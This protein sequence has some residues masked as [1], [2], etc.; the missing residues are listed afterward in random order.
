MKDFRDQ[1]LA[2][3]AS[4]PSVE[5][6]AD[7]ADARRNRADF[8]DAK[9][10]GKKRGSGQPAADL[11][12][13]RLASFGFIKS[14]TVE[15]GFGFVKEGLKDLFF[16][17]SGHLYHKRLKLTES[18]IGRSIVYLYGKSPRNGKD[19][20]LQWCFVD[21]L[22]WPAGQAPH[23]QETL[24]SIRSSWLRAQGLRKLLEIVGARWYLS[25]WDRCAHEDKT[26]A[27]LEDALLFDELCALLNAASE[28]DLGTLD[29]RPRLEASP[30][31]FA[32]EWKALG[33]IPP[34]HALNGFSLNVLRHLGGPRA[35]WLRQLSEPLLLRKLAAWGVWTASEAQER[36]RWKADYGDSTK[37]HGQLAFELI[38]AGWTPDAVECAWLKQ[39]I[40]SGGMAARPILDRI[41]ERPEQMG[42]WLEALPGRFIGELI[43]SGQWPSAVVADLAE[44]AENPDLAYSALFDRVVALDLET[45]GDKIWSLGL[46]VKGQR[47]LFDLKDSAGPTLE[48]ALEVLDDA[49]GECVL[50]V[51]HNVQ[52]WDWP[53]LRDR[54]PTR[55]DPLLWDTML[56]EFVQEPWTQSFSLGSSHRPDEDAK[57]AFLLF[58]RQLRHCGHQVAIAL[59][60]R[61]LTSNSDL[62]R[63][64]VAATTREGAGRS[65]PAWLQ[66]ARQQVTA[67]QCLVV[68]EDELRLLNWCHRLSITSVAGELLPLSLQNVDVELLDRALAGG[69]AD[70]PVS[71]A[72][73]SV[74]SWT[75]TAEIAVRLSM[76][77]LWLAKHKTLEGPLSRS[78]CP[79]QVQPGCLSVAPLPS[80]PR[81]LIEADCTRYVLL[82]EPPTEVV[83]V[84]ECVSQ[85][86][87]PFSCRKA[88]LPSV[89]G[90]IGNRVGRLFVL[91]RISDQESRWAWFDT[92]SWYLAKSKRDWQVFSTLS[93]GARAFR[94]L[95]PRK[96]AT[97]IK[98]SLLKRNGVQLY[99]G[100]EDQQTYWLGVLEAFADAVVRREEGVVP[101]LLV[102]SSLAPE[103]IDTLE[104]ALAEASLGEVSARAG[105]YGARIHS[106]TERLRRAVARRWVLVD[107]VRNWPAWSEAAVA[108]E[109]KLSAAIE[110]LPL[111]QW[112]A[113]AQAASGEALAQIEDRYNADLESALPVQETLE[114]GDTAEWGPEEDEAAPSD[115]SDLLDASRADLT[116]GS[117]AVARNDGFSAG[118]MAAEA[119]ELVKRYLLRKR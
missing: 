104:L 77:P 96:V 109:V 72:L 101:V 86:N 103:L 102:T 76:L 83:G 54:L 74:L 95:R 23:D 29:L 4:V 50:V 21:D 66:D 80:S 58:E 105:N 30:Y 59:L 48:R 27:R 53:I 91:E 14:C 70:E 22:I 93:V 60:R 51:G 99:P 81:W 79:G 107:H 31:G 73:L 15:R 71:I 35:Q 26:V 67:D 40:E 3:R 37:A 1:L 110:A 42:V 7:Q 69:T 19:E 33:V 84:S 65:A 38:T 20:A 114:N 45:D 87:V 6:V 75:R 2:L 49:L 44:R 34:K 112:F 17:V 90:G 25:R 78:I 63:L 115:E 8:R 46:F 24:N 100:S 47:K 57:A 82:H 111:H 41:R 88:V 32:A 11:V 68:P 5:P 113:M 28:E 55:R 39:T 61:T 119:G 64:I 12:C 16:H 10:R 108:A 106:R 9:L 92:A 116:D 118:R 98:P 97:S 94:S 52:G 89:A 36:G 85:E 13:E 56:T 117:E 18:D 43:S 62:M